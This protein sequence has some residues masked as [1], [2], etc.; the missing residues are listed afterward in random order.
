MNRTTENSVALEQTN[1]EVHQESHLG[2]ADSLDEQK[3]AGIQHFN[4]K[5]NAEMLVFIN[6]YSGISF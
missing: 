4:Q 5:K 3:L 1:R 6:K 2:D